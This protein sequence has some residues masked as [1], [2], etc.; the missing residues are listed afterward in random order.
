MRLKKALR[1][2]REVSFITNMD[3]IIS[4]CIERV[5]L[6]SYHEYTSKSVF[7][8]IRTRCISGRT[9]QPLFWM[10]SNLYI[11]F[12]F[13]ENFLRLTPDARE[14][15]TV[16]GHAKWARDYSPNIRWNVVNIDV[17]QI[18]WCYRELDYRTPL[19]AK[20]VLHKRMQNSVR[21][22]ATKI[23][24]EIPSLL[25]SN[26]Y[27]VVDLKK[28]CFVDLNHHTCLCGKWHSLDIACGHAIT[29]SHH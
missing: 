6:G 28:T 2:G 4:T 27:R 15:F 8:Y 29:T 13:E 7:K 21:W 10:T 25:L 9:V 14:V 20:M 26:I 24:T 19:Y 11:V 3:D 12:D 22:Q 23:P 18:F 16:I 5:F 1:Q 17:F